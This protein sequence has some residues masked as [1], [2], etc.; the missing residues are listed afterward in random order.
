[1]TRVMFVS[2]TSLYMVS[3]CKY[4]TE[5]HCLEGERNLKSVFF[6]AE[7][8]PIFQHSFW[9]VTVRTE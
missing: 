5:I 4:N 3:L 2:G 8:H 7:G 1:M 6:F 9:D